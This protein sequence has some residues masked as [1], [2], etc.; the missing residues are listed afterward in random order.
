M[1]FRQ[2]RYIGSGVAVGLGAAVGLTR[3]ME[4]LLFGVSPLDPATFGSVAAALIIVALLATYLPARK[5]SKI[6]PVDAIRYEL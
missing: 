6:D 5:A 4:A 2:K 3:L 1:P